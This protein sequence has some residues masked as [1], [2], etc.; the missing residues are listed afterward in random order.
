MRKLLRAITGRRTGSLVTTSRTRILIATVGGVL[1]IT[2]AP[3]QAAETAGPEAQRCYGFRATKVGTPGPDFLVGTQGRD[4]IV[5][6]GGD[7]RIFGLGG[8]DVIC[9]GAGRDTI[10][11]G[12]G[13]DLIAGNAGN[14]ALHGGAGDDK[15]RGFSG[16]DR[17]YGDSGNDALDGGDGHNWTANWGNDTLIGGSGKDILK[18]GAGNDILNAATGDHRTRDQLYGWAGDDKL[19]SRDRAFTDFV[20]GGHDRDLCVVDV[21]RFL[22][23]SDYRVGCE[24][25]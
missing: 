1:L 11:G 12:N 6:L 16:N 18:G 9:G 20:S 25:R 17:L 13:N 4:V 2:A 19:Y 15:L 14:D 21:N 10:Y 8:N 7:D 24:L 5:G 22:H 23:K 3:V